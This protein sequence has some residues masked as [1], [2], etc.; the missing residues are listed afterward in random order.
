MLTVKLVAGSGFI[1]G[2]FQ[3]PDVRQRAHALLGTQY[4]EGLLNKL[5][6]PY[7]AAIAPTSDKHLPEIAKDIQLQLLNEAKVPH[8]VFKTKSHA[9]LAEVANV[10]NFRRHLSSSS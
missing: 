6:P 7:G 10:A 8:A 3:P 2:G 9:D 5:E 1:K 4:S